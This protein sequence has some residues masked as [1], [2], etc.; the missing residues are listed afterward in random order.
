MTVGVPID[1][2]VPFRIHLEVPA[3]I[4]LTFRFM[5][6]T[7][8]CA[9]TG[10][11]REHAQHRRATHRRQVLRSLRPEQ[12]SEAQKDVPVRVMPASFHRA[13]IEQSVLKP[14]RGCTRVLSPNSDRDDLM[15]PRQ[16]TLRTLPSFRMGDGKRIRRSWDRTGRQRGCEVRR[17]GEGKSRATQKIVCDG[18]GH[19]RSDP[20]DGGEAKGSVCGPANACVHR[21]VQPP[22]SG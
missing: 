22:P 3:H 9:E 12:M 16:E 10:A 4:A 15:P 18:G 14:E 5:R 21:S 13:P 17:G 2:D 8:R 7:F 1:V 6:Q 20:G 19:R 11:Q